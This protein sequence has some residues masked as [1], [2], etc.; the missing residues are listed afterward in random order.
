MD[1][2]AESIDEGDVGFPGAHS[3]VWFHDVMFPNYL[4][5]LGSFGGVHVGFWYTSPI[6]HLGLFELKNAH[7]WKMIVDDLRSIFGAQ[8]SITVLSEFQLP[9]GIEDVKVQNSI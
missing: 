2:P 9:V 8:F 5:G 3:W 6:E 1:F 4:Q 7:G